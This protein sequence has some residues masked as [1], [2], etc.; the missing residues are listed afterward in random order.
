MRWLARVLLLPAALACTD[1]VRAASDGARNGA[2]DGGAPPRDGRTVSSALGT[3]CTAAGWCWQAPTPQGLGLWAIGGSA[4]DDVWA[5]GDRFVLHWDGARWASVP[6]PLE[7]YATAIW[8]RAPDDA[9]LIGRDGA[10]LRWDGRTWRDVRP[11]SVRY[12]LRAVWGSAAD[13]V[14]LAGDGQGLWHWDGQTFSAVQSPIGPVHALW[15]S[16]RDDVWIGAGQWLAHFDGTRWEKRPETLGFEVATL[17]GSGPRAVWAAGAGVARFDGERWTMVAREEAPGDSLRHVAVVGPDD[18]WFFGFGPSMRFDGRA[19]TRE[20]VLDSWTGGAWVSPAGTLWVVG[21]GGAIARREHGAWQRHSASFGRLE[22]SS[23]AALAPD[24]VFAA[25]SAGVVRFDGDAW[26]EVTELANVAG[27]W[28]AGPSDVFAVGRDLHRWNGTSWVTLVHGTTWT[29][30]RLWG[31]APDDLWIAEPGLQH[32]DGRT[33]SPVLGADELDGRLLALWG[34]GPRDVWAG[35]ENGQLLHFDGATWRR[36]PSREAH[37]T[38]THWLG[39][40]WGSGPDD[41]WAVGTTIVH[42]DGTTWSEVTAF[43]A[44]ISPILRGIW[45]TGPSDVWAAGNSVGRSD[46]DTHPLMHWDGT[47]WNDVDCGMHGLLFGIGGV[48]DHAWAVG[49]ASTILARGGR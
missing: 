42:F 1:N 11:T 20:A 40:I 8:A 2:V 47:R 36:L 21:D 6:A 5:A 45:G 25:G 37:V 19:Y 41:V 15:G 24:L 3:A 49:A 22:L 28:A 14:W 27:L 31:S 43:P 44:G 23:V 46:T 10:V 18:V 7:T 12:E 33:L 34:S 39:G 9:W 17:A 13:D 4:D 48:A 26:R 29:G 38:S 30:L 35:G 32:W 16:A